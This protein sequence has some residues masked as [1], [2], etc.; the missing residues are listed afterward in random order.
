MSSVLVTGAAGAIGTALCE[1]LAETDHDVRG[2]DVA[3]PRWDIP[4][5][6]DITDLTAS[7]DLPH[8]DVV[9]HLAAHSRVRPVIDEPTMA[10]ENVAMTE[11]VLEHA[12]RTDARV[13][14]ASS[15]EVYG[16]A[17]RPDESDAGIGVENPYG[18]SKVACEALADSY[19]A[20]YDVPVTVLRLSNVYGPYDANPRVVPVFVALATAGE[21]LRV[22]GG[23]KLVDFVYV[24]DVATAFVEAISRDQSIGGQTVT[25]GSGRGRSLQTLAERITD[26]VGGD[27]GYRVEQPRA[28][29][30]DQ[31]VADVSAAA[32]VLDWRPRMSFSDGIEATVGWYRDQPQLLEEIRRHVGGDDD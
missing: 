25:V 30:V 31:F 18:A 19:H 8:A 13:V 7:P 15:R 14:F 21:Q 28:G 4:V 23:D 20:C 1:C 17:V 10:F 11:P 5:P 29:E 16:N 22:Y 2:V 24:E 3:E 32:A 6:V 9:V 26:A 12:R 27:A